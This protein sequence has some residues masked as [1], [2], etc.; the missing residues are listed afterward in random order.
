[1]KRTLLMAEIG[2][3]NTWGIYKPGQMDKQWFCC[4]LE[5]KDEIGLGG[6]RHLLSRTAWAVWFQGDRE[7]KDDSRKPEKEVSWSLLPITPHN[8]A[9]QDRWA[10]S[11]PQRFLL[12][13]R[14]LAFPGSHLF[15][16]K[17]NSWNY[18]CLSTSMPSSK[19]WSKA[20]SYSCTVPIGSAADW[21]LNVLDLLK[22]CSQPRWQK[23]LPPYTLGHLHLDLSSGKGI[24]LP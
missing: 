11:S 1:M 10:D 3:D 2:Q 24:S 6:P 7:A 12:P 13:L 17:G 9:G 5:L 20:V 14:E 23:L 19:T 16:P 8:L 18:F 21:G 4:K 15:S 22:K